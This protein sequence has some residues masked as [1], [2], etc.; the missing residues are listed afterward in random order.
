M[1]GFFKYI[2]RLSITL[3]LFATMHVLREASHVVIFF[4]YKRGLNFKDSQEN[5]QAAFGESALA[6]AIIS[7]WFRKFKRGRENLSDDPRSGRPQM[8]Q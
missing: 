5:S 6:L 3:L 8:T 7:Y 1:W 2:F 4:N